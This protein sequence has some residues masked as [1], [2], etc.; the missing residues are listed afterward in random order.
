MDPAPDIACPTFL[1]L[2]STRV[3]SLAFAAHQ[4]H[5]RC[6]DLIE[7]FQIVLL[8]KHVH[9]LKRARSVPEELEQLAGAGIELAGGFRHVALE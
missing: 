3:G 2:D 4:R 1:G 5:G 7:F 9:L 8:A 6:S